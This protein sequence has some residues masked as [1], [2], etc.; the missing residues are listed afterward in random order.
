MKNLRIIKKYFQVTKANKKITFILVLASLLANGPYMFTSLLFSLTINY[1][2]KQNSKMVIITMIL[3]FVLKIASK[4]F[5]IISYNIEKKLYNDVYLKLQNDMIKKLD[6]INMKYFTNHSKGEILNIVNGDI[7]LLAEFGTWL[8]Q[9]I[10]LFLSFIISIIILS[11]ISISLMIL[12]CIINSIVIYI[13]NIYNDK[14][15][16][17]TK[18][19]KLKAD[20]EMQF[21]SQLLNG[22]RDIK[23]FS[24]LDQ[25]HAKYQLLNKAYLNIHDKQ[26]NNKIISNIISPS[27]T[28]CTEI[29]LMFYACYN[30][31]NGKFEIDTVLI[32]QSYF[33]T[34][35]SSLSDFISTLGELRIKNVSID[36]YDNFINSSCNEYFLNDDMI[37]PNEFCIT[38]K[39]VTFSYREKTVFQNFNL[40]LKSNSLIAIIGPSGCGKSTLFNLLLR[41]EKPTSGKILIGTHPIDKYSRIKYSQILTCVAQHPYLFNMSIYENLA[42]IDPDINNIKKACQQAEIDEYIMSLPKQYD[43]ILSDGA[44]NFSGGQQQRLAI[45]RALLKNSKI[46]LFDEITS[47]LDEKTSY[48]IF[49]TLIKLKKT[50]TILMISHKP[51]EYQQCDQIINLS[52]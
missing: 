11:Q 9:A 12:G 10:L 52:F 21:Y 5:K 38:F 46:L 17:L 3:Y 37:K 39:N 2:T 42:L 23:I 48:E 22:L 15:E 41:F 30:C 35:F 33:G 19:G 45:A 28:M 8:S 20:D 47:A 6:I 25:L 49:Q 40:N 4:L 31:L 1:L 50:H 7:K 18:E 43:T 32:I 36:R 27:I 26:I 29:I 44:L 34:L 16:I 24:I 13:L 51:S 14:F